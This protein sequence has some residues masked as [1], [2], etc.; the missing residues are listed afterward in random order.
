MLA[1]INMQAPRL[2]TPH[3]H[4]GPRRIIWSMMSRLIGE[5]IAQSAVLI[6]RVDFRMGAANCESG[7]KL[8]HGTHF[9][10]IHFRHPRLGTRCHFADMRLDIQLAH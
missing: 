3:H 4:E 2:E 1:Y 7:I 5:T 9:L 8:M 10:V 6:L